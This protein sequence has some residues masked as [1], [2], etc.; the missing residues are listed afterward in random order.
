MIIHFAP[1]MYIESIIKVH[2]PKGAKQLA[3]TPPNIHILCY[4]IRFTSNEIIS[5]IFWS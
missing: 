1:N 3:T 2:F 5:M 4:Q